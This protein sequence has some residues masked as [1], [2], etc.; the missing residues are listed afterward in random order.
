MY[1]CPKVSI[2]E[3]SMNRIITEKVSA[4]QELCKTYKVKN[5]YAFGSVNTPSFTEE[6][7]IDLLIDFAADLSAEEYTDAYFMLHAELSKLFNRKI[8][9]VTKRSL[10]NPYFIA[11]VENTKL[12]LYGES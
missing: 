6:S 5:L 8:D 10:S 3:Y 11:D 1:L 2:S 9:L 7:D 12:L 4:L